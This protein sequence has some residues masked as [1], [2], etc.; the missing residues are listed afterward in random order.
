MIFD[1]DSSLI[2]FPPSQ[3]HNS[4]PIPSFDLLRAW[5]G[6]LLR[7]LERELERELLRELLR[8]LERALER[9]PE[10]ELVRKLHKRFLLMI[11]EF[12]REEREREEREREERAEEREREDLIRRFL[13]QFWRLVYLVF[14]SLC[15]YS[16][17]PRGWRPPCTTMPWNI[18]P[19]LL[20]LWGVC[21]MFYPPSDYLTGAGSL[22]RQTDFSYCD[23]FCKMLHIPLL[24]FN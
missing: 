17:F 3:A 19:A 18:R 9:E 14:L 16:E 15:D 7:E 5:F 23:S 24:V 1:L 12:E 8:E 13:S 20:V 6:G 2:I 22:H 11:E 21:W 4:C 10:R